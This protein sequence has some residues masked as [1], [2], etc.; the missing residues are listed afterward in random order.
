MY[1]NTR[2]KSAPK[3]SPCFH[4]EAKKVMFKNFEHLLQFL[5]VKM[6]TLWLQE[7]DSTTN[8]DGSLPISTL[9]MLI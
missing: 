5:V 9:F 2:P 1:Y 3:G 6:A 7:R 8:G 4:L